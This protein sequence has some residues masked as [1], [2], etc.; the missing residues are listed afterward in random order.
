MPGETISWED[1]FY[2][3]H[4]EGR[5]YWWKGLVVAYL[6]API[7]IQA[8]GVSGTSVS[9]FGAQLFLSGLGYLSHGRSASVVA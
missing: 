7:I 2:H 4:W 5:S 3:S 9:A 6:A 8:W 1:N